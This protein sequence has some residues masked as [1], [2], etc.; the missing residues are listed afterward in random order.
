MDYV[1]NV[2]VIMLT[3]LVTNVLI[4]YA[5]VI[6][7]AGC[8]HTTIERIMLFVQAVSKQLTKN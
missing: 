2:K 6:N 3:I 7:A 8:F 1:M 5:I 4:A